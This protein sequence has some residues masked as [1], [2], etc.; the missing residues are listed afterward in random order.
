MAAACCLTRDAELSSR[1]GAALDT[2]DR[3]G[4]TALHAAAAA[5]RHA[6]LGSLI[7]LGCDIA[8]TD[9]RRQ[10]AAHV[11]AEA[12]DATALRLLGSAGADLAAGDADGNT[13]ACFAA[14]DK[15]CLAVIMQQKRR[16]LGNSQ[17]VLSATSV[18]HRGRY[19]PDVRPTFNSHI[20]SRNL[21][22]VK[23][24]PK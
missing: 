11:S 22:K 20:Y 4:R 6:A 14:H 23:E 19:I 2:V 18:A 3:D 12:G 17:Q 21:A 7:E 9:R 1:S 8:A 24:K 13:P 15:A 10:T 5:G 16:A